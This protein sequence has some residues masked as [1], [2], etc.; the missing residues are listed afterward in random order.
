M[1]PHRPRLFRPPAPLLRTVRRG[2][3]PSPSSSSAAAIAAPAVTKKAK[4]QPCPAAAGQTTKGVAF[5]KTFLL[6]ENVAIGKPIALSLFYKSGA[7]LAL[8]FTA[9]GLSMQDI[10]VKGIVLQMV[11]R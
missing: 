9:K 10:C 1:T 4:R 8:T 2:S 7:S 5:R 6:G 11:R 3:T